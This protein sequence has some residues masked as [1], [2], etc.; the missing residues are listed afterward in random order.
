MTNDLH[1]KWKASGKGLGLRSTSGSGL[2]VNKIS[3]VEWG[4]ATVRL[5]HR[6]HHTSGRSFNLFYDSSK[7]IHYSFFFFFYGGHSSSDLLLGKFFSTLNVNLSENVIFHIG[8]KRSVNTIKF[9][10]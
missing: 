10:T 4:R 9:S 2:L 5:S 1:Q 7:S 3:Y 6:S 8:S